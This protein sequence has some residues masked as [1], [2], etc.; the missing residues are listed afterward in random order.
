MSVSNLCTMSPR[1]TG[2]W[3]TGF[4]GGARMSWIGHF[5][6]VAHTPYA[7][8]T[9]NAFAHTFAKPARRKLTSDHDVQKEWGCFPLQVQL[10]NSAVLDWWVPNLKQLTVWHLENNAAFFGMFDRCLSR[11]TSRKCSLVLAVDE[12]TSGNPLGHKPRKLLNI[13]VSVQEFDKDLFSC[14]AWIHWAS[15]LSSNLPSSKSNARLA[16]SGWGGSSN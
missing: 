2:I 14:S 11:S 7:R 1:P 4:H 5:T 13:L 8:T 16:L 12:V 15:L 3:L 10:K 6:D 9:Q